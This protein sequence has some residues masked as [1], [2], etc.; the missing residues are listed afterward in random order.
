M[1]NDRTNTK[2]DGGG[3][4]VGTCAV[5]RINTDTDAKLI[6]EIS[7][8]GRKAYSLPACDIPETAAEASKGG[9]IPAEFVRKTDAELP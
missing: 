3:T 1:T 5:A 4:D 9:M 7:R 2:V 6:F 8:P